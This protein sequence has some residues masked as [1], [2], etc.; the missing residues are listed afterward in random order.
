MTKKPRF[1]SNNKEV[2]IE[3]D[4]KSFAQMVLVAESR[5]LHMKQ[6]LAHPLE[7]IPWALA[8]GDGSLRKT[9]KV[10]LARKLEKTISPAEIILEPSVTVINGMNLIYKIK[11]N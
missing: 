8:N 10:A 3:S 2:I 11:G 1:Q 5:T 6:V 4:K 7:P 9:N